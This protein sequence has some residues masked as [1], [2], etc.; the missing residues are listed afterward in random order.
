MPPEIRA[1][2][3]AYAMDRLSEISCAPRHRCLTGFRYCALS[4]NL[5]ILGAFGYLTAQGKPWFQEAI[6]NA[7]ASLNRVLGELPREEFPKLA[8]LAKNILEEMPKMP[9]MS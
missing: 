9:K 1:S 2:L 8:G 7:L 3:T 4:R 5:Q 6:P